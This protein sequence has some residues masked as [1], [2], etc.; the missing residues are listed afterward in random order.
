LQ[1]QPPI[2]AARPG[3]PPR[4]LGAQIEQPAVGQVF[5]LGKEK[6]AAVAEIGIVAL[7]LVAVITQRQRLGETAGQRLEAAEMGDPLFVRQP[8]EPHLRRRPLVAI[9]QEMLRKLRGLHRVVE[10][11][12]ERG[13]GGARAVGEGHFRKTPTTSTW[14][15]KANWS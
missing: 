14:V 12:A 7:E 1:R 4:A 9:A 3:R 5:E 8:I 15:E 10:P 2:A 6:A 13:M 11:L